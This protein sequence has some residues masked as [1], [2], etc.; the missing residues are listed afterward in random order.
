M[1]LDRVAGVLPA[2]VLEI[3]DTAGGDRRFQG[4]EGII[5]KALVRDRLSTAA[6]AGALGITPRA[7]QNLLDAL[8][9]R[10]LVSDITARKAFRVWSAPE[11]L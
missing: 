4:V 6:L 1:A 7:A 10:G 8:N 11:T 9:R 5:A 2:S 3:P